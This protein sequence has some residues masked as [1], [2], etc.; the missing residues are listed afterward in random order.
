MKNTIRLLLVSIFECLKLGFFYEDIQTILP[1]FRRNNVVQQESLMI[2]YIE[3]IRESRRRAEKL[4]KINQKLIDTNEEESQVNMP[5]LVDG[6]DYKYNYKLVR[7]YQFVGYKIKLLDR[8][9]NF[10]LCFPPLDSLLKDKPK[11]LFK[12]TPELLHY[13]KLSD[14]Q[15]VRVQAIKE[16]I[17][18]D[19]KLLRIKN[20]PPTNE[21]VVIRHNADFFL[22]NL[23]EV[24][25][26]R[27]IGFVTTPVDFERFWYIAHPK[28]LQNVVLINGPNPVDNMLNVELCKQDGYKL[29]IIDSQRCF[30]VC[31]K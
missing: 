20:S 21:V 31:Y 24:R 6:S 7:Y 23:D 8:G 17:D 15:L 2:D 10:A 26:Y 27:E 5:I 14:A 1:P 29:K 9:R 25:C 22:K 3:S 12:A 30:Y 11:S 13:E 4:E 19:R 18:F 28:T 16:E